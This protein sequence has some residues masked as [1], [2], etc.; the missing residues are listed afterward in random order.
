[1][2]ATRFGALLFVPAL[3]AACGQ[4]T[5]SEPPSAPGGRATQAEETEAISFGAALA[6]IRGHHLISL[7][8]YKAG[9]DK[10][11]AVHAVH[12]IAEILDSVSGELEGRA[13]EVAAELAE[14]LDAGTKAIAEERAPTKLAAIYEDVAAITQ[15]AEEAVVGQE[16]FQPSFK[17]SVISALLATAGQEYEEAVGRKGIRLVVE[18]QD[19][20]AFVQEG[21]RLYNAIADEVRAA[22]AEE[23]EEIEEAFASLGKAF[24]SA[25]SPRRPVAALDV[26]SATELIGHEL[27]E[28]VE[29]TPVIESDPEAIVAEIEELLDEIVE[30]YEDGN[31]AA[32]AELSAE[33]YLEKYEVIEAEVIELAPE[34]NAELEP[35]L[36]AELRRQIN[37]DAPVA[38][39]K[40][41]VARA[42]RLLHEA[43]ASV[44]GH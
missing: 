12:P 1:L 22:A 18:Y 30:S 13:P 10:G 16:A 26:T 41:M 3:L 42:K 17:G 19:G 34:V 32:A 36:G 33:A 24:P 40:E 39:I 35:L 2:N 8:L 5:T 14:R 15:R 20:Y 4:Q 44:E 9:D 29:A 27:E 21:R 43:L 28:T 6:Q 25:R 38:D 11:A 7:E 23:A 31:A 37:A